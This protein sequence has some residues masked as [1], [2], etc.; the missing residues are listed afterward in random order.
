MLEISYNGS[1]SRRSTFQLLVTSTPAAES[2]P[3]VPYFC[4]EV[5]N[6]KECFSHYPQSQGWYWGELIAGPP[7][8][9]Y[10]GG[11]RS[12]R[13]RNAFIQT[14]IFFGLMS[15]IVMFPIHPET[16]TITQEDGQKYISTLHLLHVTRMWIEMQR[17]KAQENSQ[18]KN[19]AHA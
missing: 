15:E 8:M 19:R 6:N 14:R 11:L 13:E 10:P 7:A 1:L 17:N 12:P 5:Y 3:K 9:G 18:E 2:P 16:F 4:T